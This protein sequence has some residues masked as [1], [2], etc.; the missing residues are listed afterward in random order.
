M[1][2][3]DTDIVAGAGSP[4]FTVMRSQWGGYGDFGSCLPLG[5]QDRSVDLRRKRWERRC[6]AT[7]AKSRGNEV[8]IN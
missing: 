6:S 5:G 1:D 8:N 2:W 3:Y 7:F 4:V